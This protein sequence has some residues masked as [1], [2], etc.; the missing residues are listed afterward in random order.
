M[1]QALPRSDIYTHTE[2][3]G[4]Y[5]YIKGRS[6][7]ITPTVP[8]KQIS[9]DTKFFLFRLHKFRKYNEIFEINAT[10]IFDL[11]SPRWKGSSLTN[12]MPQKHLKPWV[13]FGFN[14]KEK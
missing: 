14:A 11:I 12:K 4:K 5:P 8:L 13:S 2:F 7:E 9:L 3:S 10:N 1:N 6:L